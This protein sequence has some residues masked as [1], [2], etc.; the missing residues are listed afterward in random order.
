[1]ISELFLAGEVA[2]KIEPILKGASCTPVFTITEP[3][4]ATLA[5]SFSF[6]SGKERHYSGT[7]NLN[8]IYCVG[9]AERDVRY[10]VEQAAQQFKRELAEEENQRQKKTKKIAVA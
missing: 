7:I 9:D 5:L 1:M 4:R 3:G 2:R 10:H 8:H 6:A